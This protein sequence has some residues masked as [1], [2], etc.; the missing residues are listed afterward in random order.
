M[1]DPTPHN[2][3]SALAADISALE[4]RHGAALA[5]LNSAYYLILGDS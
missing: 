1:A 2:V 5:L 4:T 3:L